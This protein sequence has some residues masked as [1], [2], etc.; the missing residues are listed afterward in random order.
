MMRFFYLM[1]KITLQYTSRIFYPRQKMIGSPKEFY[2]RTIYVSNHAASFMDPMMVAGMRR[3]IVF[4]MT[5]SDVFTP[6]SK[7]ILWAAHMFPIY[8]QHDGEDTKGKNEEVFKKCT[9][10]LSFGRNLLIFGEGF[11]DDVFIRR[12]KPV[13]KG[14]V[15]IGFS[16]LD[17]IGWKKKI[18]IAAVGCNYSD[19]NEMRSD[20]LISTSEKICLNDFKE[21]YDQ[22]PN[23]VITE[24]TRRIEVMMQE[25]ITHVADKAMAPFH[26]NIMKLTRKGMNARNSD[27]SI[28]LEKR[29][30]YSQK[31]ANWMNGQNMEE[32]E[33][34]MS[35]KKDLE[36]YFSLL[37][38]FRIE[39]KYLYEYET[40]KGSRARELLFMCTMWPFALLGLI[41]CGIPYILVKRF[42]EKSFRRKVFWGSVKLLLGKISMGLLNIPFIFLFYHYV[43]PSYWL[44][45][46]YYLS[47]GLFGLAAYMWFRNFKSFKI[48]GAMKKM[49]PSKLWKRR[50]DLLER[51]HELIPVA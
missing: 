44:G 43:Y 11:T 2:G 30:R 41:H 19:P 22:N 27:T 49:D 24:L 25:Q 51:I 23:R 40:R 39:E 9:R 31:L 16:T 46:A 36:G 47:I 48:K 17:E 37:R 35:L 13:K 20:L 8:R 38:K 3:P 33:Q 42:V 21:A 7:P 28:P 45:F 18:Y 26:E 29:W 10:V 12:L 32:N 50:A 5:R 14:A 34:L 4:F 1:L 6:I 15:R